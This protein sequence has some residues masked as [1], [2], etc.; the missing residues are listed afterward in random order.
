MIPPSPPPH[1]PSQLRSLEMMM[2]LVETECNVRLRKE[3]HTEVIKVSGG[4][5]LPSFARV[6]AT[7]GLLL[8]SSPPT[9]LRA[10][11][12]YDELTT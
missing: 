7:A 11:L 1:L 2:G 8:T 3:G 10:Y 6:A 4:L 12:V 5:R 9:F